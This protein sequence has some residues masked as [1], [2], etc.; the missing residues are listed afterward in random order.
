MTAPYLL[1]TVGLTASFA[2]DEVKSWMRRKTKRG[3][4]AET[5]SE[6]WQRRSTE[7]EYASPLETASALERFGQQ[8]VDTR[9]TAR[10]DARRSNAPASRL[11]KSPS[12]FTSPSA[13]IALPPMRDER[14]GNKKGNG[15]ERS[16]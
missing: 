10:F 11:T 4:Q 13:S 3:N 9:H 2:K 1:P 16:V 15:E 12:A 14:R 6:G 8:L 7:I 5:V